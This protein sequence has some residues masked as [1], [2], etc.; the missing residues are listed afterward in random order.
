MG[1]PV[2]GEHVG[3]A[4]QHDER[5]NYC[6]MLGHEV[7]FGYCRAPAAPLPCRRLADCWWEIFDVEA[8]LRSH[9]SPAEIDQMRQGA[10]DRMV[11]ILRMIELARQDNPPSP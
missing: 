5:V 7:T 10:P 2:D 1:M 9:Y 4:A 6:P 8:F 11:T 3:M